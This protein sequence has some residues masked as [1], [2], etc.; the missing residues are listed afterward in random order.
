MR[1]FLLKN[2]FLVETFPT[3]QVMFESSQI[4]IKFV[5]PDLQIIAK[6]TSYAL[7]FV[8]FEFLSTGLQRAS[9]DQFRFEATQIFKFIPL[10]HFKTV[11]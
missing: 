3:I 1:E 4:D 6:N 7:D 5:S 2:L 10:L 11:K 9:T 8:S